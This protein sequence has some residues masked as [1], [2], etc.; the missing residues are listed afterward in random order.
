MI[1]EI[2]ERARTIEGLD[3]AGRP[4]P[5]YAASLGLIRA[6]YGRR[7]LATVL[8][9]LVLL[10][11]QLPML[12]V[13]L[14][15]VTGVALDADPVAA[16]AA[17]DDLVLLIV[18]GAVSSVLSTAFILVQLILLGRRGVTLGKALTGLRAVNVRTLERPGFWRGAVVRYLVMCA[19]TLLPIIGPLLV[20]ALSPLF[21]PAR[22]G[23]SWPDL[24]AAT[25]LVDA[26]RG[27]N[28]YDEKRMRIARKTVATDLLDVKT[29]LPSLATP[30]ASTEASAYVP[31]ARNKGGV[32]GAVRS[33]PGNVVIGETDAADD[34]PRSGIPTMV[35]P[36]PFAAP[37]PA[38]AVEPPL[39]AG[40]PAPAAVAPGAIVAPAAGAAAWSPPP[41]L[42]DP[43]PAQAAPAQPAAAQPAPSAPAAAAPAAAAPQPAASVPVSSSAAGSAAVALTLDS[44]DVIAISGGGVVL[45]RAPATGPDDVDVL[46]VPVVDPTRSIS[47]T[48]WALLR[49][50]GRVVALER[51]STNGSIL[52][53]GGAEQA[54]EPGRPVEVHDGDTIRF[55]DRHAVVAIR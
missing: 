48:H 26:R 43:A 28:P 36:A 8:E 53:R 54:L 6:P 17:R 41:L 38:P 5:E 30:V 1:W 40:V 46:P 4:R 14:P 25:W 33:T 29:E 47:K 34:E 42:E 20:I 13:V 45:G 7:V 50:D 12:L 55:G 32:L 51:G 15:A 31:L 27:L 11:V 49:Q 3:G 19:S 24:A 35:A 9:A 10:L 44:G 39:P 37:Q 16:L 52:V 22:R 23:R 21:D 2:D 18:L